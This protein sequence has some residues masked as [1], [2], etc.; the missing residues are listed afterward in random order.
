LTFHGIAKT[1]HQGK[2]SMGVFIMLFFSG[3]RSSPSCETVTLSGRLLRRWKCVVFPPVLALLLAVS[4]PAAAELIL[5]HAVV[6]DGNG[7]L[8]P[9]T[10][11]DNVLRW[12]ENY[13]KNCPT[14]STAHGNDPWYLVTSKFHSNGTYYSNQNNQGGNAYFAA[15]TLAKYYAYSGDA[16]AIQPVRKMLDRLLY[17]HT[18]TGAAWPN[19]PITQDDT[20]D[21]RYLDNDSEPD[22]MGMVGSAYL[23]FYKLT[24]EQKYLN[25]AVGVANTLAGKVRA[26]DAAHSPLPFRVQTGTGVVTAA[27][28]ADMFAPVKLFGDLL[29]VG[30]T[31]GG[32]YQTARDA[33]WNWV[34]A[35]PMKNNNWSGYFEDM[36]GNL[37]NMNQVSPME[38]ARY[39][40]E[41][42][43]LDPNYK[44]NVPAL[45][46][47]VKQ[48]FGQ[49]VHYGA[50]GI[51][52]QT[53]FMKEMSSHTAR[54][55]SVNA[56]WFGAL[57]NDNDPEAAAAREEARASLALSTYSAYNGY[58]TNGNSLNYVGTEYTSYCW[59][60]DSYFDYMYHILDAMEEMPE[61]APSD[62]NHILGSS[63]VIVNVSYQPE[64]VL[65]SAFDP[66]GREI[67]RL[68][69]TPRMVLA[70]GQPL[71]SSQWSF[72]DYRGV[73][74]VLIINRTGIANIEITSVPE[75]AGLTLLGSAACVLL[76]WTMMGKRRQPR[77]K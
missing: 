2:V 66:D 9:W 4:T 26:G 62:S 20:P 55:A 43:E 56:A 3:L 34:M 47:W 12:S 52:E 69:F 40:L 23:S 41:H 6:L 30:Q 31:G 16:A 17:Y 11:Y 19:C 5:D 51:K 45:L 76:A 50:T 61:L 64:D 32:S 58:S 28:T 74:N 67:L 59:F 75:P 39:I 46:D 54:Y 42:P 71:D 68:A 65:Y 48:Q 24:G 8:Q 72:G 60:S 38:T 36:S 44:Q 10:S 57:A 37:T 21:G 27:Y 73:S 70:D 33:I 77:G 7:K 15:E 1:R 49:N 25:A 63:S 18:P 22:K 14:V 35:Y 13:I 29:A 53:E